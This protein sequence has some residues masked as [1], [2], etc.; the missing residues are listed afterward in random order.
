MWRGLPVLQLRV[1]VALLAL[2]TALRCTQS[3]AQFGQP[4]PKP[5]PTATETYELLVQEFHLLGG[6]KDQ[7]LSKP[8]YDKL[9]E[10]AVLRAKAI[11]K[12]KGYEAKM[13]SRLILANA[14]PNASFVP[15][16]RMDVNGD[17]KIDFYAE[18][19][20]FPV[21]AHWTFAEID[22]D[23]D[24]KQ[25][26]EEFIRYMELHNGPRFVEDPTPPWPFTKERWLHIFRLRDV[27]QDGHVSWTEQSGLRKWRR[28]W[29]PEVYF[30]D[31]DKDFD[32]VI[33]QAEFLAVAGTDAEF[34]ALL[35]AV[36]N[37]RD[38]DSD[39]KLSLNEWITTDE[40][41]TR[42]FVQFDANDD[43]RIT[44]DEMRGIRWTTGENPDS[45]RF[46]FQRLDTNGDG[47]IS[48]DENCDFPRIHREIAFNAMDHLTVDNRIDRDEW[49]TLESEYFAIQ[50]RELVKA[51]AN[52]WYAQHWFPGIFHVIS[53]EDLD[54]D[55][56]N[57]VSWREFRSFGL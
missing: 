50:A 30:S 1:W 32:G 42:S 53:F 26:Q 45:D 29:G 44:P 28:G 41:Q 11:A 2:I 36:F 47:E 25:T 7:P 4:A 9:A 43:G 8:K 49:A 34:V 14:K 23:A 22:F 20:L 48:F 54:R 46:H 35:T 52:S 51:Q 10:Q 38:L 3:R 17:G 5:V 56:N 6:S 39:G 19:I 15:F 37:L 13:V 31:T 57:R 27:N 21:E 33:S 16:E 40:N 55:K 18:Y 24:G 12:P